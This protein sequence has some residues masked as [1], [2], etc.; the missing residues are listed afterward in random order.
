MDLKFNRFPS[1]TGKMF[2]HLC[3]KGRDKS[4]KFDLTLK[5]KALFHEQLWTAL[6]NLN[7]LVQYIESQLIVG[8]SGYGIHNQAR[9]DPYSG[10]EPLFCLCWGQERN[11]FS[12]VSVL[13]PV[14]LLDFYSVTVSM[15]SPV[16]FSLLWNLIY[17]GCVKWSWPGN[18]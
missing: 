15:F 9:W 10:T 16:R 14:L 2:L 12:G 18:E 4:R 13:L 3:I 8:P 6:L 11:R 1:R 17:T 5:F 7:S